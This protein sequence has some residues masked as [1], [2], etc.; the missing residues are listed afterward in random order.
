M[1]G[2]QCLYKTTNFS[3]ISGL[4]TRHPNRYCAKKGRKKA[5]ARTDCSIRREGG[6]DGCGWVVVVVVVVGEV[7]GWTYSAYKS[8]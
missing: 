4:D 7:V 6:G 2:V 5:K 8:T 1:E 3:T